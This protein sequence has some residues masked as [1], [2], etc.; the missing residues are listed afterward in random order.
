M[1]DKIFHEVIN[2]SAM[3]RKI[4]TERLHDRQLLNDILAEVEM[5]RKMYETEKAERIQSGS[6]ENPDSG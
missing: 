1:F 2:L 4:R 5:L 3:V 6:P